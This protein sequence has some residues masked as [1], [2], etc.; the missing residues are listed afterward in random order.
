VFEAAAGGGG[1]AAR[2]VCEQRGRLRRLEAMIEDERTTAPSS[3]PQTT[4]GMTKAI[5]EM[6]VERSH[7][8]R[9]LSMA[10]RR[11]LPTVIVRPG[12]PNARR[13]ELGQRHVSRAAQRDRLP[14]LPVR[15]EQPHPMTGYRTVIDSFIALHEVPESK[16]SDDRGYVLPAS[17]DAGT[18]GRGAQGSGGGTRH[19]ALG[20]IVDAFDPRIQGIVDNWP[21]AVG[22]LPGGGIGIAEAAGAEADRG[23]VGRRFQGDE[24]RDYRWTRE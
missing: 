23:G 20:K 15:R 12:K 11:R 10:A 1:Q 17:G 3:P 22:G 14:N 4:Y 7:P 16:L 5:C 13:L 6:L 2:G 8:Q 18:G 24:A 21:V 9:P 19:R